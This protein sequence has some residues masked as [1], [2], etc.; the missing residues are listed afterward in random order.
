MYYKKSMLENRAILTPLEIKK[1]RNFMIYSQFLIAFAFS[2]FA[3]I[4]SPYLKSQGFSNVMLGFIFAITPLISILTSPVIGKMSDRVGRREMI[5]FG[6]VFSMFGFYLYTLNPYYVFAARVLDAI[7]WVITTVVFLSWFEDHSDETKRGKETGIFMS[8]GTVG[9]MLGPFIG[10]IMADQLFVTAPFYLAI[11][12]MGILALLILKTKPKAHSNIQKNDFNIVE[13]VKFFLSKRSLRGKAIFGFLISTVF[14]LI[15]IYIPLFIISEFNLS[16]GYIGLALFF[17]YIPGAFQFYY[18]RIAD[19]ITSKKLLIISGIV[20]SLSLVFMFF[21]KSF[22]SFIFCLIL[23]GLAGAMFNTGSWTY[24]SKIGE[25]TKREGE[26]IGSYMSVSRI[27]SFLSFL[28][29]G[30]FVD[31]YGT[32]MLFILYSIFTLSGVIIF[33]LHKPRAL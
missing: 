5:L 33:V 8:L 23:F 32:R 29:S 4:L 21:S 28:A 15:D 16:Y 30:F 6:V 11:I 2:M 13:N 31:L 12:I 19:K 26:I 1:K 22:L 17:Y 14:P 10:G 7:G 20:K 18:G 9:R 25:F 3:A 24:L 27:G